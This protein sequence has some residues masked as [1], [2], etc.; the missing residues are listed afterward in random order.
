MD[1]EQKKQETQRIKS[2]ALT[3]RT[4]MRKNN[5]KTQLLE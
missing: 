2:E 3:K 5:D 1:K 4:S